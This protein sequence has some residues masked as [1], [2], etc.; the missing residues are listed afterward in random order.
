[1]DEVVISEDQG[2]TDY[3][4][5][6]VGTHGDGTIRL[7]VEEAGDE[8]STINMSVAEALA[9]MAALGEAVRLAQPAM[10]R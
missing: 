8:S 4:Y 5:V 1:M 10:A 3:R 6:E 2:T 9:L 7:Y